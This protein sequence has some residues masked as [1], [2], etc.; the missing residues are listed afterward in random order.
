MVTKK[1]SA[2]TFTIDALGRHASRTTGAAPISVA[3][4]PDAAILW[5]PLLPGRLRGGVAGGVDEGRPEALELVGGGFGA[6]GVALDGDEPAVVATLQ[7]FDEAAGLA[8]RPT[9]GPESRGQ[10]SAIDGLVVVSVDRQLDRD[11][12]LVCGRQP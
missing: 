1:L 10:P 7:P 12:I 6:L 4:G 2:T 8:G 9:H 11:V 3:H 5:R